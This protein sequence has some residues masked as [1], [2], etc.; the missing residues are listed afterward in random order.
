M[1]M[2]ASRNT[3][4]GPSPAMAVAVLALILAIAA[5]AVAEIGKRERKAGGPAKN[6]VGTRQLKSKAVTTGKLAN[7]AVNARTVANNSLTGQDINL[8]ALGTVPSASEAA[9][10]G[11][12]DTVGGHSA[13]CPGGT[14]LLRGVCF[15]SSPAG[16]IGSLT[17]ATDACASKGGWL[18]S[19]MELYSVRGVINLGTGVGTDRTYTDTYYGDTTGAKYRTIV[20]NGTGALAEIEASSPARYVC[21]YPLVR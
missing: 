10:A 14:V 8:G 5:P 18:P 16:A 17:A 1:T 19:P 21:A 9:H 12:S 6:S 7:N 2:S 3:R 20:I 15:D 11:S 13:S 4:G